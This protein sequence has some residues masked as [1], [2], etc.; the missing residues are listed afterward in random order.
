M[1]VIPVIDTQFNYEETNERYNLL[2]IICITM[3]LFKR[4]RYLCTPIN[5]IPT[6]LFNKNIYFIHPTR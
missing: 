4:Q 2:P 6:P 3:A 5:L 1:T